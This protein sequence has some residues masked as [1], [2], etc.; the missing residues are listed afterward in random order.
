[1]SITNKKQF[2]GCTRPRGLGA[3]TVLAFALFACFVVAG[4]A[5]ADTLTVAKAG[6]GSGRV[7]SNVGAIDCG[8]TCSDALAPGTLVTLTAAPAAGSQFIGWQGACA[9][10]LACTL[11]VNGSR[12]A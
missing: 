2:A 12:T 6:R 5:I 3:V 10:P 9:G 1:M 7:T 11:T 4:A 8:I